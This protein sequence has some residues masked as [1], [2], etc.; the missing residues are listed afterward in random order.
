MNL[1]K[2]TALFALCMFAPLSAMAVD[3]SITVIADVDP[4]L[5]IVQADGTALPS[6]MRMTYA[7]G[8]G[9]ANASISTR[10][11]TNDVGKNLTM[12][13]GAPAVLAN[14]INPAVAGV[15]LTVSYGGKPVTDTGLPLLAATLFPGAAAGAG[16]SIAQALQ[17]AQ[18]TAG[19]LA[20]GNY[21]GVVTVVLTPTP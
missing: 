11:L 8:R 16:S 6:T 17:V 1:F 19:E 7:P 5:E 9:L 18:T 3:K 15:P 10:I 13:L 20:A 21:Q 14:M 12:R 4:T 2:K